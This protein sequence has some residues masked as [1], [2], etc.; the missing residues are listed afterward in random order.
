MLT[1]TQPADRG[2]TQLIPAADLVAGHVI[3]FFGE[4]HRVDHFHAEQRGP[5]FDPERHPVR[6]IAVAVD[7]WELTL[8]PGQWVPVLVPAEAYRVEVFRTVT[9]QEPAEVVPFAAET[10]EMASTIARRILILADAAWGD[11]V[12]AAGSYVDT[13]AVA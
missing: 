9:P 8:Q 10:P 7:G 3:D 12:T 2:A 6:R 5:V 1:L 11:I 4:Q 13:V